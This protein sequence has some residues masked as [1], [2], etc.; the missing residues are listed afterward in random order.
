MILAQ[1]VGCFGDRGW[2][3]GSVL[4]VEDADRVSAVLGV[5]AGWSRRLFLG[6]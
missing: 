2:L 1:L 6:G 3:G 5:R 4:G